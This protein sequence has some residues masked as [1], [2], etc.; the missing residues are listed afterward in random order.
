MPVFI[1]IENKPRVNAF[2]GKNNNLRIG[3][4]SKFKRES[5]PAAIA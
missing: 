1:I 4:R 2:M 3:F 5:K